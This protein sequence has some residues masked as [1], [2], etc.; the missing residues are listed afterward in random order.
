LVKLT[1]KEN[2]QVKKPLPQHVAI[3]MDGNGRW[4]ETRG[5]NR[6]FGHLR[7]AR[8]AREMIEACS[9]RGIENLT[10]YTFSA[11]NWLRPLE[12]V[13]FLMALLSRHLKRERASLIKNNIRFFAIGDLARLPASVLEEVNE[14]IRATG[15]CTGLRLTFALSYGGRQDILGAARNSAQEIM[16]R[17]APDLAAGKVS[18]Q[19]AV[20]LAGEAITENYFAS[21]LQTAAVCDPDLIIRTSGEFRLSNFFLWQSAY[22]EIYITPTLWPDYGTQELDAALTWYQARERRYGRT[23]SQI[24]AKSMAP[25]SNSADAVTSP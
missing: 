14:T 15:H 12:E 22:S 4:A 3:I 8:I 11:E 13:S 21:R 5:R 25:K 10:L 20:R 7:G 18:A 17:L 24:A 16:A 23:S 19:E 2:E 1:D 9:E 6:T